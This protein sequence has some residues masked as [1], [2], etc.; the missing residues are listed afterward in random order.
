[1]SVCKYRGGWD[2][3]ETDDFAIEVVLLYHHGVH[4]VWVHIGKECEAA[5]LASRSITH[6]SA[7]VDLTELPEVGAETS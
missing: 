6:D 2:R 5:R 1:M 7:G 4:A 3:R